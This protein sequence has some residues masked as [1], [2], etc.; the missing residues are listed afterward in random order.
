M[1][2]SG[3]PFSNGSLILYVKFAD[4]AFCPFILCVFWYG[5]RGLADAE[6]YH[7]ESWGG[8]VAQHSSHATSERNKQEEENRRTPS[9]C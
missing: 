8:S 6:Q 2:V 4:G 1:K 9:T 5:F 3:L 7:Q